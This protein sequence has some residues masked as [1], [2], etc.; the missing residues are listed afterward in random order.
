M[1]KD[2]NKKSENNINLITSWIKDNIV[3][4]ILVF[5]F[6]ILF[7]ITSNNELIFNKLAS[8]D[9]QY[10]QNEYYRWFTAILL[11]FN[12]SHIFF[13]SL[14]LIAVGSLISP[15]I[16]KCKTAFIFFICG[17]LA[18]VIYSFIVTNSVVVYGAG[19]SGGIFA[20]IATLMVCYL[21]F[22]AAFPSKWYRVDVIIVVAFFFLAN[23]NIGSFLTHIFGFTIGIII[24]FIMIVFKIIK[25]KT[26]PTNIYP[27]TFS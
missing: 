9:L 25:D 4:L 7:V 11:H 3:C 12:F 21:R 16:G 8:C 13:N 15:F 26:L 14:A 20:L 18:E 6:I 5:V 10:M 23:D 1:V 17:A 22:P 2:S 24:A 19:S 27:A